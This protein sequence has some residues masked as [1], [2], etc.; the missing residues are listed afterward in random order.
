MRRSKD[1]GLSL[2]RITVCDYASAR[3]SI[4]PSVC[5]E[6]EGAQ[7]GKEAGGEMERVAEESKRYE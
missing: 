3:I 7:C 2:T 4:L 6:V 1:R 5:H